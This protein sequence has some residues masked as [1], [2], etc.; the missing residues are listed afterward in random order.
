MNGDADQET[1]AVC[2]FL[3][4]KKKWMLDDGEVWNEPMFEGH[5]FNPYGMIRDVAHGSSTGPFYINYQYKDA[6]PVWYS[7]IC[8]TV[9]NRSMVG[10][11]APRVRRAGKDKEKGMG[12]LDAETRGEKERQSSASKHVCGC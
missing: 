3:G 4:G 5:S 11:R 1:E 2:S 6:D 8:C 9:R 12:L 7:G 10:A